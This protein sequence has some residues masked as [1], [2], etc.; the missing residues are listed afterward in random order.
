MTAQQ[1]IHAPHPVGMLVIGSRVF[2]PSASRWPTQGRRV[3]FRRNQAI[4]FPA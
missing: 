3:T 4:S 1:R 2:A